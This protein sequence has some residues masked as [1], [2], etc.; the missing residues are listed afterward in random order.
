MMAWIH[1]PECGSPDTLHIADLVHCTN[2]ACPLFRNGNGAKHIP[3]RF[4]EGAE[5]FCSDETV[6]AA[7]FSGYLD[8]EKYLTSRTSLSRLSA[9]INTIR[10]FAE[11]FK[12]ADLYSEM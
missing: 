8:P 5:P 11:A 10:E 9:A 12:E 2:E 1:C 6:V 4:K 3:W 7:L